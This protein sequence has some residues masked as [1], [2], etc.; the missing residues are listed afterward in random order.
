MYAN[1]ICA[2]REHFSTAAHR[3]YTDDVGMTGLNIVSAKSMPFA[4][5][6]DFLNRLNVSAEI[7]EAVTVECHGL[8]FADFQHSGGCIVQSLFASDCKID[9]DDGNVARTDIATVI[10]HFQLKISAS[11]RGEVG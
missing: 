2:M 4:I 6:E 10:N 8:I 1:W 11:G 3:V 9:S 5:N 7:R